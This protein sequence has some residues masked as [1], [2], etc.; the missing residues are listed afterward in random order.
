MAEILLALAFFFPPVN[1][2]CHRDIPDAV[3]LYWVADEEIQLHKQTCHQLRKIFYQRAFPAKDQSWA[4][5]V[6][7]H[8]LAH[9]LGYMDEQDAT[10]WG[11]ANVKRVGKILR[12]RKPSVLRRNAIRWNR[13]YFQ[14]GPYRCRSL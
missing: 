3:A 8:E 4:V 1:I 13:V 12:A 9:H 11:L 7:A 5:Y 14:D 2:T 10:C 6:L